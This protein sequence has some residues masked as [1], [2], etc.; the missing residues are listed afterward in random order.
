MPS[1]YRHRL[2]DYI[3]D[4]DPPMPTEEQIYGHFMRIL[5][6]WGEDA[7]YLVGWSTPSQVGNESFTRWM[8]RLMRFAASPNDFV[9]QLDSIFNYDAGDAPERVTTR[10]QV[11]HVTGDLAGVSWL[12][13]FGG[14][15]A[16]LG[17]LRNRAVTS[18][19]V[20]GKSSC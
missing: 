1:A 15:G 20:V 14:P 5:E 2:R 9:R 4:G 13:D 3:R 11:I 17:F 19:F 18:A 10:T 16:C 6:T 7:S 12:A 8:A